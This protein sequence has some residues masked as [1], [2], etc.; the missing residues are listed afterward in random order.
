MLSV[1]D[2]KIIAKP[3]N[4]LSTEGGLKLLAAMAVFALIVA[5]GFLKL[6]TWFVLP[7]A[8][9]ELLAFG[10]AFYCMQLHANDYESITID[11]EQVVVEK[12][13][14]DNVVKTTFPRYWAQV[15]I[16]ALPKGKKVLTISSHGK[17][18]DFGQFVDEAQCLMLL[19]TLK[20]KIQ[21]KS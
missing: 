19:K 20:Q 5:L 7:F 10:L 11:E 8:G 17:A 9:L 12:Q 2:Y 13:I 6:G 15:D 14:R 4:S 16:K 3:N 1:L 21:Y 18:V